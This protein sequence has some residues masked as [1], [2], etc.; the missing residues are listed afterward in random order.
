MLAMYASERG[1]TG[2]PETS[3][4]HGLSSGNSGHPP[5]EAPTGAGV[6]VAAATATDL[7]VALTVATPDVGRGLGRALGGDAVTVGAGVYATRSDATR[8]SLAQAATKRAAMIK[9][10][11]RNFMY[12]ENRRRTP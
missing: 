1:S 11:L 8:A 6:G 2:S 7:G 4:R 12:T 5:T 9:A 3:R 10:A